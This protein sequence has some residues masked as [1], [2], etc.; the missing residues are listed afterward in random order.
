MSDNDFTETK[1]IDFHQDIV[2][3]PQDH[4]SIDILGHYF[5]M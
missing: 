1:L 3:T 2:Q 4:L 5:T